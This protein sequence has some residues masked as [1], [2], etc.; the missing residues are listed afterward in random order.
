M[1]DEKPPLTKEERR[2]RQKRLEQA[3]RRLKDRRGQ[4][5]PVAENADVA[6]P[7]G[8]PPARPRDRSKRRD[9]TAADITGLK[10][11][12]RLSPLLERLHAVGCERDTAGNRELH[13][14]EL[15]LFLLLG[16]FN[17]VVDALSGIQQASELEK[18]QKRLNVRRASLGSLSEASRVFDPELLKPI[19]EEL[20][21]DLQ[22]LGRDPRLGGQR[23]NLTLAAG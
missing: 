6:P 10:Y 12:E 20:G 13:Y 16:L 15:C 3:R 22:P 19:L 9:I 21:G 5:P 8:K 14:D 17:P 23:N 1:V 11:F 7:Q 2:R 4:R 18:V